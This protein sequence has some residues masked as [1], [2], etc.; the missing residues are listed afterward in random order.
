MRDE[1]LASQKAWRDKVRATQGSLRVLSNERASR[2]VQNDDDEPEEEEPD[3][4]PGDGSEPTPIGST[5]RSK[6][7]KS[8][9]KGLWPFHR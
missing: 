9:L 8:F 1:Q 3:F 4:D 2:P 7:K 5:R 6:A